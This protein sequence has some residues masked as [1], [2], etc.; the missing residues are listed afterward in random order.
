MSQK[1]NRLFL[2]NWMN[3]EQQVIKLGD[4]TALYGENGAGKSV[5]IDALS[6]IMFGNS[7]SKLN[8]AAADKRTAAGA[9]HWNMG[10][11]IHRPGQVYGYIIIE[12]QRDDKTFYHQGVRLETQSNDNVTAKYFSGQGTLETINAYDMK[13]VREF[14]G[15]DSIVMGRAEDGSIDPSKIYLDQAQAFKDFFIQRG[16]RANF[17]NGANPIAN[18]RSLST[19]IIKN[20]EIKGSIDDFILNHI[21]PQN[22]TSEKLRVQQ[23]TIEDLKD[24]QDKFKKL[25]I[26][27]TFTDLYIP[28]Y[29][30][31]L[32]SQAYVDSLNK[33]KYPAFNEY[34]RKS[35]A[36]NQE[37]ILKN[38]EEIGKLNERKSYLTKHVNELHDKKSQLENQNIKL[39]DEQLKAEENELKNA[40]EKAENYRIYNVYHSNLMDI[41]KDQSVT[42]Y[43]KDLKQ[44]DKEITEEMDALKATLIETKR[45]KTELDE[46]IA[47]NQGT[48]LTDNGVVSSASSLRDFINDE[49]KAQDIDATAKL[50]YECVD[51]IKDNS[52]Q[53]AV[54]T[55][56]GINR[57]G[58]VVP[59]QYYDIAVKIQSAHRMSRN[60]YV[61]KCDECEK[62]GTGIPSLL[63]FN[64]INAEYYVTRNYGQYHLSEDPEDVKTHAYVLL[65]NG[66]STNK[67]RSE[68]KGFKDQKKVSLWFSETSRKEQ[69]A[70]L[71]KT[72]ENTK[73]NIEMLSHAI[74]EK[75]EIL[76]NNE[77][78]RSAINTLQAKLEATEE[79]NHPEIIEYVKALKRTIATLKEDIQKLNDSDAVQETLHRIELIDKEI[80]T[81]ENERESTYKQISN[82][83]TDIDRSEKTIASR[84]SEMVTDTKL[85]RED[86]KDDELT[87]FDQ[88]VNGKYIGRGRADFDKAIEEDLKDHRNLENNLKFI[89]NARDEYLKESFINAMDSPLAMNT[90]KVFKES[91]DRLPTDIETISTKIEELK[92][93]VQSSLSDILM[94]MGEDYL[95][96]KDMRREFNANIQQYI[97][98]QKRYAIGELKVIRQEGEDYIFRMAQEL[99]DGDA[100]ESYQNDMVA[101]TK[102]IEEHPDNIYD[103][104]DYKH[105]IKCSLKSKQYDETDDKYINAAIT[106]SNDSNGQQKILRY[107]LRIGVMDYQIFT[108]DGLRF[109]VTD[110]TGESMDEFKQEDLF[111]MLSNMNISAIV[112]APTDKI[113][114]LGL[115]PG[116]KAYNIKLEKD[117]FVLFPGSKYT[118]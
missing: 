37:K 24:M 97:I 63:E 87:L 11:K 3:F 52:W 29:E 45:S 84:T 75:T 56:I 81:L 93:R 22:T 60:T 85:A 50:L 1:L 4:T 91:A 25:Q 61:L 23:E 114:A 89:F 62:A 96:A 53:M 55:L 82:F 16:Y 2:G 34:C 18:I 64:D 5:I 33:V 12:I 77:K 14:V 65:K 21:L 66:L 94:Q 100:S 39:L 105:Y 51:D 46:Q 79:D 92:Q 70:E 118:Y 26:V 27:R 74:E 71:L 28:K 48:S 57:F 115:K 47:E 95:M 69:L 19:E 102:R 42:E 106:R 43:L 111:E 104:F 8:I 80:E 7:P 6:I 110:E 109:L 117:E 15:K 73:K 59:K 10:N 32:K 58:I 108:P 98:N 44:Q 49:F 78:I 31:Y 90:Y 103:L 86:F 68:F 20:V 40:E 116:N 112:A 54:E 113:A 13:N 83:E 41:I 9:L 76:E 38:K 107:F 35:I 101:L 17:I 30:E 88:I 99:A 36:A 72:L 67:S